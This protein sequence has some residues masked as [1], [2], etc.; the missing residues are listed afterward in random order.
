MARKTDIPRVRNPPSGDGHH[1]T[2]RYMTAS[3][4]AER[5]TRQKKYD[6]MLTRQQAYEDRFSRQPHQTAHPRTVGCV[7]AKSCN[8]PNGVINHANPAGFVP[9]EELADYGK[10]SLLGGRESSA[11]GNI[12]LKKIGGTELPAA[13]G[14]LQLGRVGVAGIGTSAAGTAGTAG[15]VTAGVAAGAP[16]G[17]VALLWPSS[18][19][20]SALYTEEQLKSLK[21]GRTRVRLHLEQQS[22]GTLKGY[23]YNTQERSDWEKIPVVQFVAQGAQQVADFG[24]GTT[25]IWTPAVFPSKTS[26]IPPLESAPK[27]PHIWIYPPTEQADNIIVNPVYP[28]EYKDF[29]LVFPA[30]SGIKP[31]Y[32]V[33]NLEFDA[34]SYHGRTDTPVKSKVL[35]GIPGNTETRT[36]IWLMMFVRANTSN[37]PAFLCAILILSFRFGRA[38]LSSR[39]SLMV[40]PSRLI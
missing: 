15:V 37:K 21:E 2:S 7:F 4:L 23:G 38:F 27:T 18:L 28:D 16:I 6:D 30:D 1:V 3:E 12:P 11:A 24:N 26:A 34:A 25:L 36:P 8:L 20:D 32:I 9:V 29:I 31:L 13:L 19:G 33:L 10:L 22:D 14:T 17:L 40:T 39:S 5:D 35:H